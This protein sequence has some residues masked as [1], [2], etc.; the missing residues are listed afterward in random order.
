MSWT[1]THTHTHTTMDLNCLQIFALKGCIK[2]VGCVLVGSGFWA[3]G[4]V[5]NEKF[6]NTHK[7]QEWQSPFS[8]P[9][10]QRKKKKKK[11]TLKEPTYKRSPKVRVQRLTVALLPERDFDNSLKKQKE[12]QGSNSAEQT[13]ASPSL[14]LPE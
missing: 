6:Y 4:K 11:K 1:H 5:M 2:R 13:L 12:N 7:P 8:L 14:K 9:C 3:G 10:C